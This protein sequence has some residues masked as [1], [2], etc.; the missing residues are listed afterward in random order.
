MAF[1]LKSSHGLVAHLVD[2]PAGRQGA[3]EGLV[4]K[5]YNMAFALPR[6]GFDSPQVHKPPL[7]L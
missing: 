1:L 5:R 3:S 4:V 7:D 6:Q 2:L